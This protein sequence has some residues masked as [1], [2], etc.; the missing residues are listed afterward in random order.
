MEL[1]LAADTSLQAGWRLK[2]NEVLVRISLLSVKA[3][4][5]SSFDRKSIGNLCQFVCAGLLLR[6]PATK[7]GGEESKNAKNTRAE[8]KGRGRTFAVN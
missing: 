1:F 4:Q 2:I 8:N 3:A 5:Y 6:R 7:P